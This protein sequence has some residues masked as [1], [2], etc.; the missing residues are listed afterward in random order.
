MR[1]KKRSYEDDVCNIRDGNL[2]ALVN[3]E[4]H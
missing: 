3:A 1:G 4:V 2:Q